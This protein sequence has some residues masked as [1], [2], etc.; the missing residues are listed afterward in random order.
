[1]MNTNTNTNTTEPM[2]AITTDYQRQLEED[3]HNHNRNNNSNSNSSNL[4]LLEP[5]SASSS[6]ATPTSTACWQY[7]Q[8]LSM[9][10][11]LV[12]HACTDIPNCFMDA[13]LYFTGSN[14]FAVIVGCISVLYYVLMLLGIGSLAWIAHLQRAAAVDD[15]VA[16][17]AVADTPARLPLPY[18]FPAVL[19]LVQYAVIL[20]TILVITANNKN[21]NDNDD[22]ENTVQACQRGFPGTVLVVLMYWLLYYKP[23]MAMAMTWVMVSFYCLSGMLDGVASWA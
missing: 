5:S 15:A 13:L 1:M 10:Y 20:I 21:D 11:L 14:A 3:E 8:H 9:I 6:S 7:I 18:I 19:L 4:L 17:D 23:A 22:N 2:T 12:S 16:V